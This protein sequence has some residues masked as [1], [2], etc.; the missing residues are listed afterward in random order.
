[1]TLSSPPQPVP[2]SAGVLFNPVSGGG[3]GKATAD[4]I[5]EALRRQGIAATEYPTRHAGHATAL[6]QEAAQAGVEL[7][8]VVG[9]DGTLRDAT[10]GLDAVGADL[11]VGLIPAGTGND[12]ARTLKLPRSQNAALEVA[13]H[14]AERR[15]DLWRWNGSLFVNVSGVGLDAAVATEVN[16][17]SDRLRGAPAY[18][19]ALARVLPRFQPPQLRL[20]WP[21]GSWEGAAWLVA[22]GNGQCYGGGMRIAPNAIP[23]DG[24]LDVVV[25]EAVSRG[26]LLRQFPLLFTGGHVKHPRV[27]TFR[28]SQVRLDGSSQH[29]TVDG[30]LIG[31]VPATVTLA[32]RKLRL[33]VPRTAEGVK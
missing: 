11:P 9:G 4:S 21:E 7:L 30:E 24:L 18:I 20:E 14:G 16:S 19:A 25:I 27:R 10:A 26:E 15:L 5:V 23:D 8:L 22:F 33:R 13:L 32:E 28:T 31:K 29:A 2:H 12:L 3:R 17:R 6:A 1:M